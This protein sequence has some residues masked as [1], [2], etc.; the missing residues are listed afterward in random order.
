ML[1]SS[2]QL[3]CLNVEK[4]NT[5]LQQMCEATETPTVAGENVKVMKWIW[6]SV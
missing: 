6:K 1:L 4:N 3:L 2:I 5:K